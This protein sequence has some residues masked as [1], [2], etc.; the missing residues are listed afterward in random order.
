MKN[1]DLLSK[2]IAVISMALCGILLCVSL[3][4]YTLG[5]VTKSQAA[6]VKTS[7]Q[8]NK[9]TPPAAGEIMMAPFLYADNCIGVL[10]WNTTTGKSVRYY[11]EGGVATKKYSVP[12]N[13]FE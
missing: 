8:N 4:I 5:S 2:R 10:V 11:L 6:D 7:Y 13:P 12:A 3:L 9:L 1:L